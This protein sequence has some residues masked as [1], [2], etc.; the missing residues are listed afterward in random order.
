LRP[1][2]TSRTSID[3]ARACP[4]RAAA[5]STRAATPSAAPAGQQSTGTPSSLA[6][7]RQRVGEVHSRHPRLLGPQ[8]IIRTIHSDQSV[9][10]LEHSELRIRR[11]RP[12]TPRA[13]PRERTPSTRS[14]QGLL[15]GRDSGSLTRH[16]V[17]HF[18]L[19]IGSPREGPGCQFA[20]RARIRR[21]RPS[22]ASARSRTRES[23]CQDHARRAPSRSPP[24]E[25]P[26]WVAITTGPSATYV[27]RKMSPAPSRASMDPK[28]FNPSRSET[29]EHPRH[30]VARVPPRD[31]CPSRPS[32]CGRQSGGPD[33]RYTCHGQRTCRCHRAQVRRRSRRSNTRRALS[34][35]GRPRS[36]RLRQHPSKK[37]S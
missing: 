11:P 23:V 18:K 36:A 8:V 19:R 37:L 17:G 28:C 7:P 2:R 32:P 13:G 20:S 33:R 27:F 3:K 34:P 9:E 31:R 21:P 10:R 12:P 5:R 22:I 6:R 1:G 4:G 29:D 35:N 25:T 26:R 15:E 14:I 24:S 30:V 16:G